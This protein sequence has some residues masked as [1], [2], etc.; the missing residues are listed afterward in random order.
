MTSYPRD[1]NMKLRGERIARDAYDIVYARAL[2]R[3]VA[4][5][6]DP[7]MTGKRK[8][9]DRT[10]IE[11]PTVNFVYH[12]C[13]CMSDT[14]S[15][16]SSRCV[17]QASRNKLESLPDVFDQLPKLELMRVAVNCLQ[18]LPP[19]LA[20]APSLAWI[21]L[22]GNPLCP[23]PPQPNHAI[24]SIPITSLTLSSKLGDGASG[25][26][27]RS[28]WTPQI[29]T[30]PYDEAAPSPC[31][32]T[33]E[34]QTSTDAKEMPGR[35]VCAVKLFKED[36]SP[37]GQACDEIA[38]KVFVDHPGLTKVLARVTEPQGVVMEL[39]NGQPLAA[40]PN[41]ESLLRCRWEEGATFSNRCAV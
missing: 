20:S 21:S 41:L 39:V 38:V 3:K 7:F 6:S 13:P 31:G 1:A 37:D 10:Q 23:P 26:V 36:A 18:S 8:I 30:P 35:H 9:C 32:T 40:K 14:R 2:L 19:S 4:C 33:S 24:P 12:R 11:R 27:F 28:I 16:P 29:N 17:I 5:C 34:S 22:A 15:G 25:D